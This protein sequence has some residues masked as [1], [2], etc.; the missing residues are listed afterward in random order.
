MAGSWAGDQGDHLVLLMSGCLPPLGSVLNGQGA[1]QLGMLLPKGWG[2]SIP[3]HE[4]VRLD[5]TAPQTEWQAL[6]EGL[7]SPTLMVGTETVASAGNVA[8]ETM[9]C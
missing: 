4:H 7:G 5:G 3:L 6:A 2:K 8:A 9:R 1:L